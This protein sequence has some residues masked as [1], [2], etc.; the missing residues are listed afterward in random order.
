MG[1]EVVDWRGAP[2]TKGALVIYGSPVSRSITLVE[3]VV[4]GFTP[5]GRVWVE[6]TRRSYGKY[7]RAEVVHVGADRLTVVQSRPPAA[8]ETAE[9]HH[10]RLDAEHAERDRIAATHTITYEPEDVPGWQRSP[11]CATCGVNGYWKLT[12]V[13][14]G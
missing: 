5:S 2:I 9:E 3:G 14:C 10:Q 7:R 4:R 1:D 8:V 6:V 11:V 13:E 12:Q